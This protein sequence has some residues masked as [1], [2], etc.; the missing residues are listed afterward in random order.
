MK[1]DT[2]SDYRG[3]VSIKQNYHKHVRLYGHPNHYAWSE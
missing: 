3:A 2:T 1:A